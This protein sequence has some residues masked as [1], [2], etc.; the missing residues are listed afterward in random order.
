[1]FGFDMRKIDWKNYYADMT[2]GVKRYLVKEDMAELP[3]AKNIHRR[4]IQIIYFENK[5]IK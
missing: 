1:M 4:Y 2:I 3:K 5:I